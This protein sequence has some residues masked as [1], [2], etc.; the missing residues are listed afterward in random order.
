M[1]AAR[2]DAYSMAFIGLGTM[3]FYIYIYENLG[4]TK[5]WVSLSS[6]WSNFV[7]MIFGKSA[8]SKYIQI[9]FTCN[10]AIT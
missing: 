8:N 9:C 7:L 4:K 10:A 2:N 3:Y 1:W 5:V 6:P